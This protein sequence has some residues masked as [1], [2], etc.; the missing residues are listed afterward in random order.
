MPTI[1]TN[2][3]RLGVL[4][5]IVVS[6]QGCTTLEDQIPQDGPDM[7]TV[8]NQ[9]TLGAGDRNA[10]SESTRRA[11]TT[12]SERTTKNEQAIDRALIETE[13]SPLNA[14]TRDASNELEGLFKTLPN[15]TLFM[16][17]RP[18]L[19]GRDGI[20]VPGYTTQFKMFNRDHFALPGEVQ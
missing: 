3:I 8:Y 17:T 7:E 4:A 15:P 1:S 6:A 2:A 13:P 11:P 10:P 18:H 20:P 5:L 9:Y 16:Y 19:V 12:K 14:Y